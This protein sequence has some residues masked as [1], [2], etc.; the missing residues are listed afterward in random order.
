MRRLTFI[1]VLLFVA[2]AV[3][4][5]P[6]GASAHA[7]YDHSTPAKSEYLEKSPAAVDVWFNLALSS[8]D[9]HDLSV[10][11]DKGKTVAKASVA[12]DVNDPT[13]VRLPL[14]S[15]LPN[16]R[17][18][19]SW[20]VVAA[21]FMFAEGSYRFYVGVKP[22]AA[23]LEEDAALTERSAIERDEGGSNAAVFGAIGGGAAVLVLGLAFVVWRQRS[24]Y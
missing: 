3:F 13:H 17:Y 2:A 7:G 14:P 23:Q 10:K 24:A 9:N 6:S 18:T 4:S 21:D 16:G 20:H 19:V 12:A 11:D 1:P 15:D 5:G 8:R 22:T